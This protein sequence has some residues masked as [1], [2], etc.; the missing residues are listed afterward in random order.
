MMYFSIYSG[1]FGIAALVV[2]SD[3]DVNSMALPIQ[4]IV[5]QLDPQLAVMDILT[6]NQLIGKS[7][8][9]TSFD[10]TLLLVFAALSLLLAAVGLFGVLSYIAAQRTTEIGIRI[11]LGAQRNQ[12]LRLMLFNGMRPALLG[13]G[14][15]LAASAIT[16]RM[17]QSIL[18]GTRPFDPPVYVAAAGSLLLVSTLACMLPAWRASRLNP[19]EALRAE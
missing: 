17:I 14:F 6:M 19:I 5:Q 13:L 11:A 10:A 18:F 7:I 2:R 8:L 15:G 12:V 16:T 3:G 4:E 9:G 1:D